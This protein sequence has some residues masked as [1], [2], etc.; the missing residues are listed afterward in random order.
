[1]ATMASFV[2]AFCLS[3][4]SDGSVGLD[5]LCSPNIQPALFIFFLH[6]FDS[7]FL[8]GFGVLFF[9]ER[10]MILCMYIISISYLIC[11]SSWERNLINWLFL[12]LS[13]IAS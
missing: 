7:V 4:D 9:S 5:F 13:R 11:L 3:S 12:F 1:M 10:T 2:V 8:S 6:H